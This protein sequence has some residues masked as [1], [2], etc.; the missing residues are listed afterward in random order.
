MDGGGHNTGVFATIRARLLWLVGVALIPAIAIIGYDEYRFRLQVF[1]KVEEDAFRQVSLVDQ[2]IEG[3]ISETGRRCAL[4]ARLPQIQAMDGS[5]SAMLAEILRDAPYYINLAIADA[6]GRVVSSALPFTGEVSVRDGIFFQRA[7]ATKSFAIGA[8]YRNPISP[9]TGLNMG[10]PLL[11]PDSTVRGVLWASLALDW[12]ADFVAGAN[13]PPGAVLLIVDSQGQVLM[14]SID[15]EQWIGRNV[16]GMEIVQRMKKSGAGTAVARGVDGVERLHAFARL[17]TGQQGGDAILSIGIPTAAAERLA[18]ASLVRNLGILL[19]GALA[20]FALAW[21][22]AERFFLR[23]TRALLGTARRMRSGDLTGRTGLPEGRGELGEVARALDSGLEALAAAQAEMAEAKEAAEAANHAKSAFLA[24]MSHEIRTPMNAIINMTGLALDTP[25]TPRQQQY[26]SVAHGSARNLLAIINDILDFSKIE[27]EKLELEEAAFS[28]RT[29]LDEVTET[30]RAKVVEKHVELI[31]SVAPDVPDRI[32]GDALRVRQVLT[33]LV[34]NAFKFTASGEVVVR[35]ARREAMGGGTGTRLQLAVTVRDTGV[36]M[37]SE[38]QARLFQAFSQADSSTSR[39]YGG[40]GL[41]LA[42]S[43]RLARMMGGDLTVDSVAGAGSTFTFTATL[44]V[45]EEAQAPHVPSV[46]E[47]VRA[48]PVLVIEDNDTSRELLEMFLNSWAVRVVSS[49]SAEEGLALLERRNVDGAGD[50][51]GLVVVDWMLPG[52]NGLD[53]AARIRQHPGLA[54]L[55]IILISAYAGKEEERRCEELG[56]NVFLPKPITASS[57]FDAI[58]EAEGAGARAVRRHHAAPLAREYEGV[59]ALLAEDNEA[60]QMVAT[61]LLSILGVAVDIAINGR[62]AVDMARANPGGYA[63][64]FMDMQMPE[65]DG[66]EATQVIRAD[67]ALGGLPIIAMTANAMKKDLD[68]CLAA[69]M[70]DYVTKP[71]DRAALAATLRRWMP[72]SAR[73]T[74]QPGDGAPATDAAAVPAATP[75]PAPPAAEPPVLA[76]VNLSG[77]LARLGI[78]Y[79]ALRRMLIRFADGQARTVAD[80]RAAVDAGDTTGAARH[81]HALAG[82]AGN[83]GA[84][85]LRE[86]AKA[87]ETAAR[88]GQPDLDDLARRVEQAA[89]VVFRSVATL[90]SDAPAPVAEA[91]ATPADSAAIGRA[92][93][94]LRQAL[95]AGD[96]DATATAFAA[97][98]GMQFPHTVRAAIERARGLA[99]EYQFDEADRELATILKRVTPEPSK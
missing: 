80:L 79:D 13:L 48:R 69:G 53:T 31:A 96:P 78:G 61:E 7:L 68:A 42:I 28:V 25:L 97:L 82:S 3:E 34:G 58:M 9:R 21:V 60:N 24:V 6:S 56:I 55:P 64:I 32:V 45:A 93:L 35:V 23:E 2:Q 41:G 17:R 98:A 19:A 89:T 59:K 92:F 47:G 33:N 65:M 50:P 91:P 83:L 67:P 4:L 18:R 22:A 63:C 94:A 10:C 73:F 15:A 14:R 99:D 54:S 71:I 95:S 90:R 8:F 44:G 36:G 40:T 16:G 27:A 85:A 12:T 1:G 74:G 37:T 72:A 84:D 52:M 70:N 86:A 11:G 39:K 5:S 29:V 62:E 46:P 57:F 49:G 26:L 38:Q 43:R 66:I 77:A 75:A 76:G 81:A 88:G 20:C 51:F 30:F 87:L